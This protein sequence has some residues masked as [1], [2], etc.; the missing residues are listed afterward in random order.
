LIN[1][2]IF[3][4]SLVFDHFQYLGSIGPLALAGTGLVRL[5]AFIIPK[6]PW[7]QFALCAELL[8]ILGI[9]S[10]QRT[11][12][13]ESEDA[14]W[15]DELAKN[16]NCWQGHNNL[17]LAFLQKGQVDEALA[18]FQKALEIYPNY[19][20][21]FSNLGLALLQ[22]GRLDEA[23]TNYQKALEMNAKSFVT[24]NDLGTAFFQ[25][26][27]LDEAIDQFQK[28]LEI[29]PNFF[30]AHQ[31]LGAALG[32]KGKLDEAIDQFRE[33][34]RLKPDYSPAQDNL[35]KAQAMAR[36]RDGHK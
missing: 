31:N 36:Q 25:K 34:L 30:E 15:T 6:K 9:A 12:V 2:P 11:W 29:K 33:V 32:Q 24:H 1:N 5:L 27:Q 22:K 35:D 26:G 4:L 8:L 21:A 16:P 28:A 20:E 23:I 14:L 18:K 17:G 3:R 7:L 10:W 19:A 13:Y